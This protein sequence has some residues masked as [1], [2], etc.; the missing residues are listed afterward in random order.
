MYSPSNISIPT[1][2]LRYKVIKNF[3]FVRDK[4]ETKLGGASVT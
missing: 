3:K 4:F 1:L 2:T